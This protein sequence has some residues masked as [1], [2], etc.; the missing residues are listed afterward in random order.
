MRKQ[1][2][3]PAD[4]SLIQSRTLA[5]VHETVMNE[6]VSE[7]RMVLS[8]AEGERSETLDLDGENVVGDGEFR[9]FP[10]LLRKLFRE[11][12]NDLGFHHKLFVISVHAV[13]LDSGFVGFNLSSGKKIDGFRLPEGLD[14]CS[15]TICLW[16]T[17]PNLLATSKSNA[18][19]PIVLKLHSFGKRVNI[20]GSLVQNRSSLYW[21]CMDKLRFTPHF[22][23]LWVKR[24]KMVEKVRAGDIRIQKI[25][26]F[27]KMV[28]DRL[29]LP[30]LTELCE[31]TGLVPP[32]NL[33]CLP[34]EVKLRILQ[35]LPAADL[36][37][38]GIVSHELRH[39]SLDEELWKQKFKEEFG[40]AATAAG[41]SNWK[42]RFMCCKGAA[43]RDPYPFASVM[44][45]DYDHYPAYGCGPPLVRPFQLMSR[46]LNRAS[47]RVQTNRNI[48]PPRVV[49]FNL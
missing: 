37:K 16:Y 11:E 24:H 10:L 15:S 4:Q 48:S 20:F 26:E 41:G 49:G 44:G 28:K 30:L 23:H 7:E 5:E 36:A 45:E 46:C 42:Q 6:D 22:Y 39:L 29:A 8:D 27:W 32:T 3:S 43:S 14:M 9:N 13:M 35:L 40:E 25:F 17:F 47:P 19:E 34:T 21:T 38:I 1:N 18:I 33:M 31:K 12:T 2:E